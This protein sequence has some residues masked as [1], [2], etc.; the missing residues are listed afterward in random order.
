MNFAPSKS[1]AANLQSAARTNIAIGGWKSGKT[2]VQT[3]RFV[4]NI[5]TNFK[6]T[7]R[8]RKYKAISPTLAMAKEIVLPYF[9]QT[10]G[11][12]ESG[13]GGLVSAYNRV[14]KKITLV[15]GDII[16]LGSSDSPKSLEGSSLAGVLIDEIQDVGLEAYNILFSKVCVPS[17]VMQL[18]CS[19]LPERWLQNQF[20]GV[21]NVFISHLATPDNPHIDPLM[22]EQAR[23]QL[24][25]DELQT[26]FYG[27]WG[28]YDNRLVYPTY[29]PETHILRG[30]EVPDGANIIMG[31]DF[32]S[33][34]PAYVFGYRLPVD[35]IHG[36]KL[37]SAGDIVI[38]REFVFE[39]LESEEQGY[40]VAGDII[41]HQYHLDWAGVDP[42]GVVYNPR[43]Y[44]QGMDYM[45]RFCKGAERAGMPGIEDKLKYLRSGRTSNTKLTNVQ[46]AVETGISQVRRQLKDAQGEIHLY[47]SDALLETAKTSKNGIIDSI[48]RYR[49]P[50][51]GGP[52]KSYETKGLFRLD[53]M[54]ALRYMIRH[55]PQ[56]ERRRT[57]P[58]V[59][60]YL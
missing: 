8:P 2:F 34:F 33:R 39:R 30:F 35:T 4:I 60:S 1:Q 12:S 25:Y 19:G 56:N 59:Q 57:S 45:Q 14:D 29:S 28:S 26:R 51:N 32:G 42:A 27:Q 11:A 23:Q 6:I 40:Y 37:L 36:G 10:L 9:F 46:R 44:D 20:E 22:V 38:F 15:T 52:P 16:H 17:P 49:Y 54:D 43:A 24:S 50:K 53:V 58:V 55:L 48:T 18:V 5:L 31:G 7:G 3:V 41:K 47:F 13:L 21:D